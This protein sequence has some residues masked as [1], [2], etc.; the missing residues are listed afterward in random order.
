MET[1]DHGVY[2]V[3]ITTD[4]GIL[5]IVESRHVTFDEST[6]PGAPALEEYMYD[7]SSSDD[8]RKVAF[9]TIPVG[10]P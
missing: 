10:L 9:W 2:K 1:L 4:I 3:L 7:E 8:C 6:F 5:R